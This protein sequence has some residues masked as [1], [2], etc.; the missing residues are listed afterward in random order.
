MAAASDVPR[1]V[2]QAIV[3]TQSPQALPQ[4]RKEAVAFIEQFK[5]AEAPTVLSVCASLLTTPAAQLAAGA[6]GGAQPGDVM[7]VRLAAYQLFTDVVRNRWRELAADQRLAATQLALQQFTEAVSP[8]AAAADA[9]SGAGASPGGGASPLRGKAA[10]LLAVVVRQQGAAAYGELVPQL[11]AGA[12]AG[13][14]QAE[15]T[16]RVLHYIS[17]DLTQ[18][19]VSGPGEWGGGWMCAQS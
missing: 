18:F 12:A 1:L 10:E 14:L 15:L 5:R 4:Q 11:M 17:E 13:P 6:A 9:A 16:C 2:L 7:G 8:A 19:E 3:A